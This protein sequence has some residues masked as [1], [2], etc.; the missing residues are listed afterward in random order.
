MGENNMFAV[1]VIIIVIT[2]L[3]LISL[4]I[5]GNDFFSC[6]VDRLEKANRVTG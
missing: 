4:G 5:I 1:A 3:S 6:T 2:V